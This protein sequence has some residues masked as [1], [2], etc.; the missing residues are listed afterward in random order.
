M[1]ERGGDPGR[2]LWCAAAVDELKQRVEVEA[3]VASQD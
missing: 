3:A 1:V 2:E